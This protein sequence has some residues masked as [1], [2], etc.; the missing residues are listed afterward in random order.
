M[1]ENSASSYFLDATEILI[2]FS[3]WDFPHGEML[4]AI[5]KISY[6]MGD[7]LTTFNLT[8][9]FPLPTALGPLDRRE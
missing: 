4:L 8:P 2:F 5:T 7:L 6:C 1:T 9:M 3:P